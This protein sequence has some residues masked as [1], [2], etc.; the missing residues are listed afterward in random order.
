MVNMLLLLD[1][2]IG[3]SQS[4]PMLLLYMTTGD[5]GEQLHADSLK[6]MEL[7]L[8]DRWHRTPSSSL[9]LLNGDDG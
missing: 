6:T 4:L 2:T 3:D 7:V 5:A 8:L 1:M 9:L